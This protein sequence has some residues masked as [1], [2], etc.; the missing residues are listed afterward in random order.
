MRQPPL[1]IP[2]GWQLDTGSTTT[3]AQMPIKA[4]SM[5]VVSMENTVKNW[6][7]T[8]KK[9][10]RHNHP[11]YNRKNNED[12]PSDFVLQLFAWDDCNIITNPLVCVEVESKTWIIFL[13]YDPGGLFHRLRSN[14]ALQNYESKRSTDIFFFGVIVPVVGSTE[15]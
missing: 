6:H 15:A 3:S 4:S 13:D 7:I 14:T 1:A 11:L 5:A 12:L 10:S 8:W 9:Y 2:R